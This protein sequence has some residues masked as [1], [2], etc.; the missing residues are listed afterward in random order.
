MIFNVWIFQLHIR[1]L[2]RLLK[3]YTV[4]IL[5]VPFYLSIF[6]DFSKEKYFQKTFADILKNSFK[7]LQGFAMNPA[8]KILEHTIN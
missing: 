1:K 3:H 6:F 8:G 4:K 5:T 7:T 2:P